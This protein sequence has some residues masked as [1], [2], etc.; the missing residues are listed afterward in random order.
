MA[1]N[2]VIMVL[3]KRLINNQLTPEGRLRVERLVDALA[4]HRDTTPLIMFCGGLSDGQHR[5]E[6]QAMADYFSE[7]VRKNALLNTALPPWLLEDSSTTSVENFYFAAKLLKRDPRIRSYHSQPIQIQLLST[8]YH[9]KRIFDVQRIM[10]S[11]GML[12]FF[13]DTLLAQGIEVSI[14]S[15]LS[16][17]LNVVNPYQGAQATLFLLTQ[18]L[19]LYCVYLEGVL[20]RTVDPLDDALEEPMFKDAEQIIAAMQTLIAQYGTLRFAKRYVSKLH[21]ALKT[22]SPPLNRIQLSA[23]LSEFHRPLKLLT[24]ACDPDM[25]FDKSQG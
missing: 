3:G 20:H 9:L 11:Q 23:Q 24:L 5:S 8:D 18:Q 6:A 17:H 4:H 1:I 7:C 10:P 25:A 15:D 12:T 16:D 19:T 2:K 21:K 13:K 22:F 14:S